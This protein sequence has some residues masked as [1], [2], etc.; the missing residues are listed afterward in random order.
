MFLKCFVCLFVNIIKHV[1]AATNTAPPKNQMGQIL[2][3]DVKRSES[4]K[5][6]TK[7]SRKHETKEPEP[8][9]IKLKRAP[10]K[11]PE[12]EETVKIVKPE[13]TWHH[14]QEVHSLHK[15][16]DHQ[17]I[18]LRRSTERVFTSD[19][20]A[21]ALGHFE[22]LE[23]VTDVQEMEREGSTRTSKPQ[24]ERGTNIA[25]VDT[26]TITIMA[27]EE[28]QEESVKLKTFERSGKLKEEEE[29]QKIKQKTV[30]AKPSE[31]EKDAIAHHAE[32]T[33][34]HQTEMIVHELTDRTY[35][36][37]ITLEGNNQ[38]FTADE[39]ASTTA[40][41]HAPSTSQ[42]TCLH[43]TMLK[44]FKTVNNTEEGSE[45]ASEDERNKPVGTRLFKELDKGDVKTS[46][47]EEEKEG[48]DLIKKHSQ[49]IKTVMAL[50]TENMTTQNQSDKLDKCIKVNKNPLL[51]LCKDKFEENASKATEQFE[52]FEPKKT[53][54][55]KVD[56]P[57][58][59][60]QTSTTEQRTEKVKEIPKRPFTDQPSEDE[61][62]R[63]ESLPLVKEV[64]PKVVQMKKV[65]RQL[66]EEVF[67][68]EEEDLKGQVEEEAWT[69]E[70]APTEEWECG[71][72]RLLETPGM[73]GGKRG[74]E[75]SNINPQE[76]TLEP[77]HT[78]SDN[79]SN[80]QLIHI[81][82]HDHQELM[83]SFFHSLFILGMS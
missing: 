24:K 46:A 47:S 76:M 51:R 82:S 32:V 64:S 73:P 30:P 40:T 3:Q 25:T 18:T 55:P 56:K 49:P 2:L 21:P 9:A 61:N 71:V 45:K 27:K 66:A 16:E 57:K 4:P 44:P 12:P 5:M 77:L 74:E 19:K 60:E 26:K 41:K 31:V 33:R 78:I 34:Q 54:S 70:L 15:R 22:E 43:V 68:E 53:L 63:K 79:S 75:K 14:D 10:V 1:F 62:S 72:D 6:K 11:S 65:P 42:N 80:L 39:K 59:P 50:Q 83:C 23:R 35:C 81:S 58:E 13:V 8:E 7:Y 38:G 28:D 52:T 29:A 36:Q 48:R 69:W 20:D 37:L 17:I 67:E